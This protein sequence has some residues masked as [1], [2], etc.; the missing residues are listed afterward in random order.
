L[1]EISDDSG[2]IL[3]RHTPIDAML[4]NQVDAVWT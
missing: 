2:D 1:G 3:N 4:L